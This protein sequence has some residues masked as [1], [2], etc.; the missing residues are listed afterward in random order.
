MKNTNLKN[1]A[2][3]GGIGLAV[4]GLGYLVVRKVVLR[5]KTNKTTRNLDKFQQKDP[6][7][8]LAAAFAQ[9]LSAAFNPWD[10]NNTWFSWLPDGTDKE[11]C[12]R[13]A[14]EMKAR[15]VPFSMVAK[16]YHNL[17]QS[18]LASDLTSEL[19][20]ADLRT[21]YG[22]LGMNVQGLTSTTLGITLI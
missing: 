12:F 1:A 19:D 20:S 6:R 5:A 15:N 9:Q 13:I 18:D 4:A 7:E 10:L 17:F 8:A 2:I 16:A 14:R 22:H 11:A 3:V 21:F